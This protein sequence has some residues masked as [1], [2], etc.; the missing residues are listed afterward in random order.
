M[1]NTSSMQEREKNKINKTSPKIAVVQKEG[2][3]QNIE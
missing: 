1:T 2:S 3:Q